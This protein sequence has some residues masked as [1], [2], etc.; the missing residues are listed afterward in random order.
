VSRQPFQSLY[1]ERFNCP[2]SEYEERVFKSCLYWHAKLLAPLI[3]RLKPHFFE[4]DFKFIRQLGKSAGFREILE[5][6]NNFRHANNA[7]HSFWR[8]TCRMRVSGPKATRLAREL[9]SA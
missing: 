5:D 8:I 1:C 3:L 7:N 2:P 6:R 9:F 4:L